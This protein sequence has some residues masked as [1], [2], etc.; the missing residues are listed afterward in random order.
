MK[1]L[2]L[3]RLRAL[4]LRFLWWTDSFIGTREISNIISEGRW[5]EAQQRIDEMRR[6]W[7]EDPEVTRLETFL[8]FMR[9]EE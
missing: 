5:D 7:G 3:R 1:L 9:D 8:S 6:V 4:S 2:V